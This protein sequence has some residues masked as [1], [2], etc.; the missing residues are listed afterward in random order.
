MKSVRHAHILNWSVG[1]CV[2][3][4]F[5]STSRAENSFTIQGNLYRDA[6]Q[7][8]NETAE[9]Q[10]SLWTL[11]AGGTQVGTTQSVSGVPVEHALF[12]TSV[13]FGDV[14][15]GTMLYLQTSV[16]SG[17]D[18][19]FTA[20]AQRAAINRAPQTQSTTAMRNG[21][22]DP[23]A[24]VSIVGTPGNGVFS[25]R[26]NLGGANYSEV[27]VNAVGGGGNPTLAA[28]S[29]TGP[30]RLNLN[31]GAATVAQVGP[32]PDDGAATFM[33]GP[34]GISF[35]ST[36][37]SLDESPTASALLNCQSVKQSYSAPDATLKYA[38]PSGCTP[39]PNKTLA[40]E[41]PRFRLKGGAVANNVVAG[42]PTP[43]VELVICDQVA[44]PSCDT[45]GQLELRVNDE[46]VDR[47]TP[48]GN[49][50]F[51]AAPNRISGSSFNQVDP[52]VFGAAIGGGGTHPGEKPGS[53]GDDVDI[54]CNL[55]SEMP[56]VPHGNVVADIWGT[57][58]GGVGNIASNQCAVGGGADNRASN[59]Y[60]TIAGGN[61]NRVEHTT[62][63]QYSWG[64][65]GGGFNNRV[66]GQL[67]VVP[68][69][70]E[71]IAGASYSFAAGSRAVARGGDD[72]CF[73][74]ADA[75][76]MP[77]DVGATP[78]TSKQMASTAPNQ[79]VVRAA[80]G[81]WFGTVGTPDGPDRETA[82]IPAG[83]YIETSTGGYLS[84]TGVWT[85]SCDRNKKENFEPVDRADVLDRVARLPITR[86][87]YKN[88]EQRVEHVGP[89]AQDFHEIFGVGADDKHIAP[90]D[91]VGVALAAIQGL[92]A[93]VQ[94]KEC[95]LSTLREKNADLE[96][97]LAAIEA[98]LT[99]SSKDASR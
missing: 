75:S 81:L 50:P 86:W 32:N 73:V 63:T 24:T 26:R 66:F 53:E 88:D 93:I 36:A 3:A 25:V 94:E 68:G 44:N 67:G 49:T 84:T 2:A 34:S 95:E 6:R 91:T 52:G 5:V 14:F 69:G 65:V 74:W 17:A 97:R 59:I 16:K 99:K 11:P 51:G 56:C 10:F 13:D 58:A 54:L 89:V 9:F 83:H 61:S 18:V 45:E 40:V 29:N 48:V 87:N 4:G 41:A 47:W 71:N 8:H 19:A 43:T 23:A 90:L 98:M 30:A 37:L 55:P 92:N 12:A 22:L 96:A 39:P 1:L 80:G 42:G 57:I 38:L 46:L 27:T 64:A 33:V 28:Q 35:T 82:V 77:V 85:D 78:S 60:S 15:D 76:G 79:F 7:I 20:M 21:P 62:G 31:Y 72:G 70:F